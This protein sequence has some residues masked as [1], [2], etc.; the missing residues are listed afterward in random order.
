M[1]EQLLHRDQQILQ[2][3][4]Q[5]QQQ[6]QTGSHPTSAGSIWE[7]LQDSG[8]EHFSDNDD[9]D[10][11]VNHNDDYEG[12]HE[13]AGKEPS[14][15]HP[16][17]ESYQ[18][19][20]TN[21]PSTASRHHNHQTESALAEDGSGHQAA[22]H[23]SAIADKP[24]SYYRRLVQPALQGVY[25]N[26]SA[27]EPQLPQPAVHPRHLQQL[28]EPASP[29]MRS[30]SVHAVGMGHKLQQQQQQMPNRSPSSSTAALQARLLQLQA[31][32][33]ERKAKLGQ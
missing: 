3:Q 29:K 9:D 6:Q 8:S 20:K 17:Q 1:Q 15:V 31:S 13:S 24:L 10:N 12:Q 33:K 28:S 30:Q 22:A 19:D 18:G 26:V 23:S 11:S 2:Y 32:Y 16:Q 4:Q 25:R 7:Q 27:S 14:H 21:F 5:Q